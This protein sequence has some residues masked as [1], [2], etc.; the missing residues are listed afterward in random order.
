MLNLVFTGFEDEM[1]KIAG[2]LDVIKNLFKRKPEPSSFK[3]SI[4]WALSR[5]ITGA[6]S[7][8][9]IGVTMNKV[10]KDLKKKHKASESTKEKVKALLPLAAVGAASGTTKGMSEKMIEQAV[11]KLMKLK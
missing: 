11:S 5:G 9:L 2:K 1:V 8:L 4:P 3:K 7:T 10:L 6:G